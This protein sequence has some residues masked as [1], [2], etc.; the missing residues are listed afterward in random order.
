MRT[1]VIILLTV[2]FSCTDFIAQL[3]LDKEWLSSDLE[4]ITIYYRKPGATKTPSP[5]S[6]QID[7][8]LQQ[9]V[10]Y[11]HAIQDSLQC[12]FSDPVLIYLY[13]KDESPDKIG[14]I[15]GGH[16]IPRFLSVYYTFIYDF[17]N[18][19]LYTDQYGAV[20]PYLSAHELA[21]VI[22]IHALGKH[23]SKMMSEGYAVWLD[24]SYG[25]YDIE[26]IISSYRENNPEWILSPSRLITDIE[27]IESIYYPNAGM[28]IRFLTSRYGVT[29]S[30]K[31]F[32]EQEERLKERFEQLTGTP[33]AT[34]EN[35]YETYL[36][37]L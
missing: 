25:R 24:G 26:D 19:R 20:N 34:M 16:A 1:L 12:S 7:T 31:L 3:D 11:Y 29:V 28:F 37:S 27:T 30:N 13:N 21:H 36:A 23:G 18:I 2:L 35:E 33:W 10:L 22:A 6:S 9:Q 32:T 14:T 4:N 17:N 5:T 15:A 8:I